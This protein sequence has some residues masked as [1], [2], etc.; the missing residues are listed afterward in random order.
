MGETKKRNT[1]IPPL[2]VCHIYT[3]D[4]LSHKPLCSSWSGFM[5]F[6]SCVTC[7]PCT[8]RSSSRLCPSSIFCSSSKSSDIS[9]IDT[10]FLRWISASSRIICKG[11]KHFNLAHSKGHRDKRYMCMYVQLTCKEYKR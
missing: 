6:L 1:L 5:L 7:P 10:W 4:P 11:S 9:A 8:F 3:S 2:T